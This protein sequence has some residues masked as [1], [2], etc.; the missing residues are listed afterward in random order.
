MYIAHKIYT[1]LAA[2][3]RVCAAQQHTCHCRY[4]IFHLRDKV[5]LSGLIRCVSAGIPPEM[6]LREK[7]RDREKQRLFSESLDLSAE[8]VELHLTVL[9]NLVNWGSCSK[10]TFNIHLL[11][12]QSLIRWPQIPSVKHTASDRS[13]C[14]KIKKAR[15]LS[16]T[17]SR[18]QNVQI[19]Q[20]K[21]HSF[22]PERIFGLIHRKTI[23]CGEENRGGCDWI[24]LRQ[25]KTR[26]PP[27]PFH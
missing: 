21:A 5:S 14:L 6:T 17:F 8:S 3:G 18:I 11:S 23:S 10:P 4:T 12:R 2:R 22:Q 19:N 26:H 16:Y 13:L 9:E 25:L 20:I 1:L 7:A 27:R 24:T 15:T